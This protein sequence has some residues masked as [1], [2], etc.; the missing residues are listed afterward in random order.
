MSVYKNLET[1]TQVAIHQAKEHNCNY[2]VI[3]MNPDENGEFSESNGSTY[4]MVADSFFNKERSNVK[5]I[6]KTDDLIAQEESEPVDEEFPEIPEMF[7]GNHDLFGPEPYLFTNPYENF[8]EFEPISEKQR[9]I[10]HVPVRTTPKYSNNEP[11][12]CESGK[13]Y[14]KCCK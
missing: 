4:E 11:C 12:P 7:M 10:K 14:K 6:Y 8:S 13:K 3:L 2:N 9:N 1:M 5:L